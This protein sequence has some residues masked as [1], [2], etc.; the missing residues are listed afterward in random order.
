MD[1]VVVS[2]TGR[3]GT[4]TRHDRA[5]RDRRSKRVVA[6]SPVRSAVRS[7]GDEVDSKGQSP[8]G[9]IASL[10]DEK[11]VADSHALIEPLPRIRGE[12]PQ[13]W[14]VGAVGFGRYR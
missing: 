10:D 7:V 11:L 9:Y 8:Q 14:N 3:S 1:V 5:G 6:R 12:P 4:L 2:P 13:L